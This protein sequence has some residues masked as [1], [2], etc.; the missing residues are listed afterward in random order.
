MGRVN[1]HSYRI[2]VRITMRQ[3]PGGQD[4]HCGNFNGNAADDDTESIS[5]RFGKQVP[6]VDLLFDEKEYEYVGCFG[7]LVQD[8]D[9]PV[10]ARGRFGSEHID[11]VGCSSLCSG[12]KF[13]GR[14]WHGQCFCGDSYGKHGPALGCACDT[15]YVGDSRNCVYKL[16]D[17][18]RTPQAHT[19]EDCPKG[20]RELALR[21][22][23][24]NFSLDS[25]HDEHSVVFREACVLDFCFGGAEFVG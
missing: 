19:I 22:C 5:T 1:R 7:D 20:L 14:Q 16:S 13:F 24:K 25:W 21:E 12:Y 23:E 4:G 9:L 18:D 3:L 10:Q 2:D 11:I 15:A 6:G 8:R 17:A